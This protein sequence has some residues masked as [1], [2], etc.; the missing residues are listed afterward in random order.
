MG[1]CL[2]EFV[3][4][5]VLFETAFH[6]AQ[7]ALKALILCFYPLKFWD[8]GVCHHTQLQLSELTWENPLEHVPRT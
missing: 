1:F 6:V 7:A 3:L 5:H 4:G 8:T 2:L